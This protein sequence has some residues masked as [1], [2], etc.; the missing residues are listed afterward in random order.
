MSWCCFHRVVFR[1]GTT[2]L[3]RSILQGFRE[4]SRSLT[5]SC[6][7][8]L[9]GALSFVFDGGGEGWYFRGFRASVALG[10]WLQNLVC[11]D[12]YS[13]RFEFLS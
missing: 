3:Y 4:S 8:G 12:N 1:G 6:G 11:W 2:G 13:S 10:V 9:C 7:V 5:G